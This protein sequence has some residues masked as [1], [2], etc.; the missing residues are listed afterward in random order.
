MNFRKSVF[1]HEFFNT[2]LSLSLTLIGQQ[3]A[4][5][6]DGRWQGWILRRRSILS[7]IATI[8]NGR[9][10]PAVATLVTVNDADA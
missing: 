7:A 4:T 6:A 2:N 8:A 5:D 10:L 1:S 9:D 3:I